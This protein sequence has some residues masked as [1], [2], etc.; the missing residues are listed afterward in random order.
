MMLE[1]FTVLL[2]ILFWYGIYKFYQQRK[3]RPPK[4]IWDDNADEWI[5]ANNKP[6]R[7]ATYEEWRNQS[8]IGHVLPYDSESP[9][10]FITKKIKN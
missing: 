1:I 4:H 2:S 9:N 8:C 3:K 10:S 5:W 6:I 7:R